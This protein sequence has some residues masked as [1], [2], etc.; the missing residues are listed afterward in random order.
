LTVS[1]T[2]RSQTLNIDSLLE[3]RQNS[4]EI[5]PYVKVI[6]HSWAVGAFKGFEEFFWSYGIIIDE[7]TMTGT[8]ISWATEV[9]KQIS[10]TNEYD[11]IFL[12]S[13]IN[14]YRNTPQTIAN[15]FADFFNISL[16]K[17]PVI[18][19]CNIGYYE[20]AKEVIAIVNEWLFEVGKK[21]PEIQIL[22]LFGEIEAHKKDGLEM[23]T[24]GLHPRNYEPIQDL[25]IYYILKYYKL[26]DNLK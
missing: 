24:D 16:S 17:V 19:V 9:A 25:F 10:D 5:I 7:K 18:F 12:L 4:S 21:Y 22:D 13:G 26:L 2:S 15:N 23:S 14:D 1:G 8:S 20:P 3:K 6:G 11:A